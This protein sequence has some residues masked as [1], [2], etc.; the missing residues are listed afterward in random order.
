VAALFVVAAL[1]CAGATGV[2]P[3][4]AMSAAAQVSVRPVTSVM[5]VSVDFGSVQ[6]AMS[7]DPVTVELT[8]SGAGSLSISRFGIASSSL[9]PRDFGVV[10]GGTCSLSVPLGSGESCTVLVRFKPT[11]AGPRSGLLSFWDNTSVGRTNV[12]LAGIALPASESSLSPD[13]VDFGQV[14]LGLSSDPVTVELTN[15]GAGI[16]SF[17]RFGIA[18]SSVNPTDF[19]VVA[20]GTCAVSEPIASGETCTVLVRFKPTA[21]GLRTGLLS[22]W[23][24][25]PAGRVNVPLAGAALPASDSSLSPS[26]VDFGTVQIGGSTGPTTVTLTNSGAGTLSFWRFGIASSSVNPTDFSVVAGGTCAVSMTLGS[27]ESCTVLVRFKPTATGLR[28][29]LLSFWDNTPAGRHDAALSGTASAASES[30]ASPAAVD[31][32]SL[33]VGAP[34]APATV[35]I[36]NSGAGSLSFWRIGIATSSVNPTDFTVVAGGTC[37]LAT[38]LASGE[39]CTV[40]VRFTPTNGGARSGLLSFWDNTVAGRLDV[41]LS[42]TGSVEDPCGSGCF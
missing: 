32:G 1:A 14:Q 23:D 18:T 24:N 3:A 5:P 36:T 31:F 17:W 12:A 42:G 38:T 34:S 7:S 39:S 29:G 6:L 9:N 2:H 8:N 10:A 26:A 15:S 22:F 40:L 37:A 11:S 20:G 35:T 27:G 41:E 28:T 13:S 4:S 33:A 30:S 16:L 21:T 19:G 25:S